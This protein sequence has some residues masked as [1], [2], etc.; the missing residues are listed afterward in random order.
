MNFSKIIFVIT[1]FCFVNSAKAQSYF[2]IDSI[3]PNLIDPPIKIGSQAW[4]KEIDEIIKSQK[5]LDLNILDEATE[6]KKLRPET[7][8]NLAGLNLTRESNP[9]LY[10][11][12][13][14]TCETSRGTNEKIKEYWQQTRPYLADL[15]VKM[16][17]TP[18]DGFSYPSGHSV[19]SYIYAHVLGLV[20]PEKRQEFLK[21]AA[22]IAKNRTLVGMHYKQD[23]ESGKQLALLI[24]GGLTQS[25]DFQQDL[26]EAK[27]E[28]KKL[29]S[30]N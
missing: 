15:R 13:D 10:K 28:I 25:K 19:G 29:N 30:N 14:R 22:R 17:I 2:D 16:L 9:K 8:I 7:L 3:S 24:V 23:V 11:L 27:E 5:N 18:S 4:V 6:E 26:I 20:V 12:L 1:I 21:Y